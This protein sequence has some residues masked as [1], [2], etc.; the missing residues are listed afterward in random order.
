M[1][2]DMY[3]EKNVFLS[4]KLLAHRCRFTASRPC[5][6]LSSHRKCFTVSLFQMVERKRVESKKKKTV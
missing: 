4:L 1:C 3:D 5:L 2:R 6:A